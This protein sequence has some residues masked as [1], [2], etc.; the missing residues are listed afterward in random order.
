MAR[1]HVR[2]VKVQIDGIDI[3]NVIHVEYGL[4]VR[5]NTINGG[6][7]DARPRLA[8]IKITRMS[9]DSILFWDWA[10]KPFR[11][12]FRSGMVEYFAPDEETKVNSTLAWA[13]GFVTQYSETVPHVQ[14]KREI[15][16]SETI[17]ISAQKI[18]IN[19]VEIEADTWA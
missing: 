14:D 15:P 17:E 6:P 9:D 3:P 13:E 4:E 18:K 12:N 10:S 11:G 2:Q 7:S 8:R 1:R 19:D 16:Q 5:P